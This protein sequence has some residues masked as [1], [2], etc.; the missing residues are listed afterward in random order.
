MKRKLFFV[1]LFVAT[2]LIICTLIGC[3]SQSET[4]IDPCADGHQIVIDKGVAATCAKGGI[5]DGKFCGRCGLVIEEQVVIPMLDHKLVVKSGTEPTCTEDGITEGSQCYVCF[6]IFKEQEIVQKLGH[7]IEDH[8]CT[9]CD[10]CEFEDPTRYSSSYG[11]EYLGTLPKGKDLQQ[12]YT[13]I[14]KAVRDFHFN[15]HI[16][17]DLENENDTEAPLDYI[18]ITGLHLSVDD[19]HTVF[20]LYRH[21]NPLYYW[22]T[23]SFFYYSS[24]DIVKYF[25]LLCEDDY[26][27]GAEREKNN[28]LIYDA[29]EEYYS[30][31]EGEGSPYLI[32]LAYYNRIIESIDYAYESDGVTPQDGLWA[33]SV[34]GVFDKRGAVCESYAK[35]LQLLLNF[36]GVENIYVT[37][38]AGGAHAWNLVKL[39][40]GKWY[41]CDPTWDDNPNEPDGITYDYFCMADKRFDDHIPNTPDDENIY[42]RLYPLPSR[43]PVSFSSNEVMEVGEIFTV[44]GSTYLIKGYKSVVCTSYVSSELPSKVTYKGIEYTVR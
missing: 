17:L 26:I 22:L 27:S 21:D 3:G 14:D 19:V 25:W 23:S 24:N 37:G 34:I 33:H 13:M 38:D 39:D 28:K 16:N 42:D 6:K 41:W 7:V 20:I 11:Y 36:S 5:S 1:A 30:T 35:T 32:T 31:V 2:I 43:S 18:Y 15:T 4:T 9:R 44:D 8:R 40:D 29:V 10:Y 12:C